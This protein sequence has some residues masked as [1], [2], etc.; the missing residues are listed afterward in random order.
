MPPAERVKLRDE[1]RRL[2]HFRAFLDRL[3]DSKSTPADWEWLRQHSEARRAEHERGAPKWE[4]KAVQYMYPTNQ[5]QLVRNYDLLRRLGTPIVTCFATHT[6]AGSPADDKGAAGNLSSAL[7]LAVGAAVMFTYNLWTDAGLANGTR[8]VV[9]GLIFGAMK[10]AEDG[11]PIAILVQVGA[12]YL[13]P[14]Y[15]SSM[16]R[17]VK[18]TE[19]TEDYIVNKIVASRTAFPLMLAAASTIHK[20]QGQTYELGVVDIGEQ[21]GKHPGKSYTAFSRFKDSIGFYCRPVPTLAR[22][23]WAAGKDA[24]MALRK[25]IAH[26]HELENNAFKTI[27]KAHA[28]VVAEFQHVRRE[29]HDADVLFTAG[30]WRTRRIRTDSE[31]SMLVLSVLSGQRA[32]FVHT[33][34]GKRQ[35]KQGGRVVLLTDALVSFQRIWKAQSRW[36]AQRAEVDDMGRAKVWRLRTKADWAKDPSVKEL[37]RQF[38][39]KAALERNST[40]ALQRQ[41]AAAS[42]KVDEKRKDDAGD[43]KSLIRMA[44][45]AH[46]NQAALGAEVFDL[47]LIAPMI[48]VGGRDSVFFSENIAS[49]TNEYG[50]FPFPGSTSSARITWNKP[51]STNITVYLY[52]FYPNKRL[53]RNWR[54]IETWLQAHGIATVVHTVSKDTRRSRKQIGVSCGIVAARVLTSAMLDFDGFTRHPVHEAVSSSVLRAANTELAAAGHV[55]S[56]YSNTT[57]TCFLSASKI[58]FLAEGY[59]RR[60]GKCANPFHPVSEYVQHYNWPFPCTSVDELLV[61]IARAITTTG[62]SRTFFC[63]NSEG[64]GHSGFHW[65]ACIVDKATRSS[66]ANAME[67]EHAAEPGPRAGTMRDGGSEADECDAGEEPEEHPDDGEDEDEEEGEVHQDDSDGG[68]DTGAVDYAEVEIDVDRDDPAGD[69]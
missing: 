60:E 56:S 21:E 10:S 66:V 25:R 29:C 45:W 67:D 64:A 65:V 57:K 42:A 12:G 47:G 18:V 20:S 62:D 68:E 31:W 1:K 54:N 52:D 36:P 16:P 13:G 3:M 53:Q 4:G 24:Q 22:L 27:Q 8:G 41:W 5:A 37:H 51:D 30:D 32:A 33:H 38:Q 35:L 40:G 28:L 9:I 7:P 59:M 11:P 43:R 34:W 55:P 6:G 50:L 2:V 49:L 17:V 69:Y 19:R 44:E 46:K 26:E 61:F 39:Q 63:T 15:L 48:S 23:Q 14:S 58:R